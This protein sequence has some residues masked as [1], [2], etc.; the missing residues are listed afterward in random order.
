MIG[1]TSNRDV[2]LLTSA[3]ESRKQKTNQLT[4]KVP[5]GKT[6]LAYNTYTTKTDNVVAATR[7]ADIKGSYALVTYELSKRTKVYGFTGQDD[8][9]ATV[10]TAAATDKVTRSGVGIFHSF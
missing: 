5:L 4:V 3:T 2:G 6:E 10:A 8:N 9:T 7:F 1:I